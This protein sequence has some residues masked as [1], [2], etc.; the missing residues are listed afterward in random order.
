MSRVRARGLR[1]RSLQS[2]TA[3]VNPVVLRIEPLER[4]ALLS[5]S[6]IGLPSWA[7]LGSKPMVSAGSVSDPNNPA[8][9]AVEDIAIDPANPAHILV[10]SVNGG[11]WRTTNGNRGFNGV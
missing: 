3:A 2:I 10:S 4:R 1:N 5:V 6:L 11:I 8:S 9:G 7:E